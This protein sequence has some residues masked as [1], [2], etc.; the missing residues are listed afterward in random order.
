MMNSWLEQSRVFLYSFL[1]YIKYLYYIISYS[2][3]KSKFSSLQLYYTYICF[4]LQLIWS[5]LSITKYVCE[6]NYFK[7][8]STKSLKHIL[9]DLH[10]G[11]H[12][13][14]YIDR[15]LHYIA[16]TEAHITCH[17]IR[18][19]GNDLPGAHMKQLKLTNTKHDIHWCTH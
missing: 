10:W 15:S 8:I 6:L 7:K 5:L 16:N 17:T 13:I 3:I 19:T 9:H 11:T 18:H 14:S 4:F 12:D 2:N 1:I